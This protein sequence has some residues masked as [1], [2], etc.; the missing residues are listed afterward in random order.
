MAKS[1]EDHDRASEEL[2]SE[3]RYRTAFFPSGQSC[4]NGLS[5]RPKSIDQVAKALDGVESDQVGTVGV[6]G[7]GTGGAGDEVE[8]V[9]VNDGRHI[10][11]GLAHVGG[12]RQGAAKHQST[13]FFEKYRASRCRSLLGMFQRLGGRS[14]TR[15]IESVVCVATIQ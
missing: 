4:L 8:V 11:T 14:S 12:N 15:V 9:A 10:V 6:L 7:L 1:A 13:Q 5:N 2:V 3:R